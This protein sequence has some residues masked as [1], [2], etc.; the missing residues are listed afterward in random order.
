MASS[1]RIYFA[2]N[3][4]DHIFTGKTYF[5]T[6]GFILVLGDDEIEN[7]TV[8]VRNRLG[9]QE[10]GIPLDRFVEL[11]EEEI[12]SKEINQTLVQSQE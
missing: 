12:K 10:S 5:P 8:S 7:K 2:S 3:F 11:L 4:R 9:K 1:Y 6:G